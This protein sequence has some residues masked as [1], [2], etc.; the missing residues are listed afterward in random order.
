M[1]WISIRYV[2]SCVR[3]F[4]GISVVCCLARVSLGL[5]GEWAVAFSGDVEW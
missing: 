2:R 1:Y 4:R 5:W 3:L